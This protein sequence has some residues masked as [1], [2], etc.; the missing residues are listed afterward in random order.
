MFFERS[1]ME[2]Q[3]Y[4]RSGVSAENGADF[5]DDGVPLA[6]N[7]VGYASLSRAFWTT[8]CRHDYYL[9]LM[10]VGEL[11]CGTDGRRLTAGEFIIHRPEVSYCYGLTEEAEMGYYWVHFTGST[12]ESLLES[13]G[14]AAGEV[15]RVG[16]EQSS[17]VRRVFEEMFH[18]FIMRGRGCEE[19]CAAKLV[20]ILVELGR[21]AAGDGGS[22]E[23][24]FAGL[25]EY[26]NRHYTENLKIAELAKSEH[27]SVSR[28]REV[29]R[30]TFGCAPSEYITGLRLRHAMD[31]LSTTDLS[32][33]EI[34]E[35]CGYGDVMYFMR[36]FRK[37]TG[38]S[39][40]SYRMKE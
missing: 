40:R 5:R 33:S 16:K 15:C 35:L 12:V 22:S 26:I 6:V 29:F 36:L 18:E 17:S 32:I 31:L 38:M 7:C 1:G 23:K 8:G 34:A 11:T 14:L 28:F 37:K 39:A 9:Q 13:C 24:R 10:D 25:L 27:L 30:A 4:Y 3:S 20:T 21:S 19:L 2:N